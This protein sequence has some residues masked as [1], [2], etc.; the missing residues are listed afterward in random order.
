MLTHIEIEGFRSFRDTRL[1][2]SG[3]TVLIGPNGSGKSNF[4]DVFALMASSSVGRLGDSIAKRGGINTLLFRGHDKIFLSFKF[5]PEGDFL[6]EKAPVNY[7][8][9]LRPV[10]TLPL[11]WFEQVSINPIPPQTNSLVLMHRDRPKPM[12]LF[13]RFGTEQWQDFDLQAQLKQAEVKKLNRSPSWPSF[14]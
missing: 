12:A 1:D 14:K 10:G 5:A 9:H 4:L 2:L 7:K 8:L 3:L 11:I 6:S 13:R